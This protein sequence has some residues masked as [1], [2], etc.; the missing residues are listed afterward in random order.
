MAGTLRSRLGRALLVALTPVL[1]LGMVGAIYSFSDERADRRRLLEAI[2]LRSAGEVRARTENGAVILSAL[3][4]ATAGPDCAPRLQ[5]VVRQLQGYRNL[6]RLTADQ[7][8]SCAASSVSPAFTRSATPWF[9]R[10]AAGASFVVARTTDEAGPVL[11]VASRVE[12]ADGGFDG[13]LVSVIT[14]ASLQPATERALPEGT[15]VA[16]ADRSGQLITSADRAAFVASLGG[17]PPGPG[18]VRL[19]RADRA[20]GGVDVAVTPLLGDDIF[21]LLSSPAPNLL[22]WA[23]LNP[24]VSAGIPLLAFLAAFAAVYMA[25]DR[26]VI[27]W[28]AYLERVA[29]CTRGGGSACGPRWRTTRRRRF[30]RSRRP[31]ARWP[32]P[33]SRGTPPC[34]SRWRRRT[35]CCVR[36]TT[37]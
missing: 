20:G 5:D 34:A 27:R 11:V 17:A 3:A 36:S 9:G 18:E 21:L 4:S 24:L 10:L 15:K 2:A 8:V 19:Y 7:R 29:A 25:A 37:G 22:F 14:P 13:A 23:R 12:R 1:L 6:V 32:T 16:L 35:R 26:M 30:A 31:W 33:S 28:L